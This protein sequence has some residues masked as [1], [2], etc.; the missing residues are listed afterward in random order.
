MPIYYLTILYYI[1]H[2]LF[3]AHLPGWVYTVRQVS[4]HA[5]ANGK[6]ALNFYW[7]HVGPRFKTGYARAKFK[8]VYKTPYDVIHTNYTHNIHPLNFFNTLTHYQAKTVLISIIYSAYVL[9]NCFWQQTFFLDESNYDCI[10][11][12]S[13]AFDVCCFFFDRQRA[14]LL[15]CD[16]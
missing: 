13:V 8:I 3:F 11:F 12:L 10:I 1:L 16:K 7:G 9:H 4:S 6:N 15:K 14:L 2:H 5:H